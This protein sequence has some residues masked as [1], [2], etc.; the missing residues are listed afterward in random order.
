[1]KRKRGKRRGEGWGGEKGVAIRCVGNKL[2]AKL[3]CIQDALENL[4]KSKAGKGRKER[5][6]GKD[7]MMLGEGQMVRVESAISWSTNSLAF[8]MF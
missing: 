6:R 1:M 7:G 8:R 2:E 5:K 4:G 3:P